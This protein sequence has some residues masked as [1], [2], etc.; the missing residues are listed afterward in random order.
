MGVN[1]VGE[2]V[3]DF[4]PPENLHG[5]LVK[6]QWV[7]VVLIFVFG[8]AAAL[9]SGGLWWV[10]FAG[11]WI[12]FAWIL[13]TEEISNA[14]DAYQRSYS[15]AYFRLLGLHDYAMRLEVANE[16]LKEENQLLQAQQSNME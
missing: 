5:K 6:A 16:A 11:F 13:L 3:E 4:N 1:V 12:P 14:F 10:L 8:I 2:L 15:N 9:A 7:F